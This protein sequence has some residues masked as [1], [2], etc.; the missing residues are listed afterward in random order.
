MAYTYVR[1]SGVWAKA[2]IA[3]LE[4]KTSRGSLVLFS[5]FM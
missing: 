2:R 5:G 4:V 1:Y 3:G